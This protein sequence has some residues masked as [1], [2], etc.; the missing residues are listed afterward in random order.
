MLLVPLAHD[1]LAARRWPWVTIA[2]IAIN[3]VVFVLTLSVAARSHEAQREALRDCFQYFVRHPYLTPPP[4]LEPALRE[5]GPRGPVAAEASRGLFGE[6]GFPGVRGPSEKERAEQQRTLDAL[7]ERVRVVSARD[8]ILRFG[9]VPARGGVLG[10]F[11]SQFLHG[12]FL[13]LLFNMWFLWLVGVNME[14][15]WGRVLFSAFYLVAGALA[16]LAHKLSAPESLVPL[17]GASGAVAGAMGAFLVRFTRTRIRFALMFTLRT[18][19][20]PVLFHAPAYVMLPLWLITQVFWALLLRGH[21]SGGGVAYFAHIGGFVFGTAFA[22]GMRATGLEKRIDAAIENEGAVVQDG[23]LAQA[24]KEIERGRPT[25]ALRILDGLLREKPGSIDAYL[26]VLRAAKAASD[27]TRET[28]AYM[29]LIEL[30]LEQGHGDTAVELFDEVQKL[31]RASEIPPALRLRVGRHL[32]ALQRHDAAAAVYGSIHGG[33][34]STPIALEAMVAHAQNML[35]RR[36][37]EDALGLFTA[38]QSS[39]VPLGAWEA[40]IAQGMEQALALPDPP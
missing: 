2:I 7:A 16:C 30:Y 19:F 35:R 29:K 3:V 5:L 20:R 15:A 24:A 13:H 14:D 40:A 34:A 9:Y 8:P 23:H 6:S 26:E 37:K 27:R 10:L 31:G 36:R 12:G 32:E 4:I 17:I 25:I 21:Q 11:S 39:T 38:A 22:L 33:D 18:V 28:F 1:S